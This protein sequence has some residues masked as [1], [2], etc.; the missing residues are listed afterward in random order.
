MRRRTPDDTPG[1]GVGRFSPSACPVCMYLSILDESVPAKQS[2]VCCGY[3]RRIG[4]D[5]LD[6]AL[7]VSRR[8]ARYTLNERGTNFLRTQ[9]ASMGGSL[10]PLAATILLPAR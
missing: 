4:A 2:S 7:G 1:L 6:S 3:R 10:C 9:T 8:L 5:W